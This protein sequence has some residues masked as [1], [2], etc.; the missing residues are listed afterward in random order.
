VKKSLKR[1]SI[2]REVVH[3]LRLDEIRGA[4]ISFSTNPAQSC[5]LCPTDGAQCTI[6]L[7]MVNC[8]TFGVC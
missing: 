4:A 2:K 3:H 8:P 7:T 6:R 5:D 1:L